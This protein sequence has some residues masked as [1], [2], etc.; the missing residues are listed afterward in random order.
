MQGLVQ[1]SGGSF[2]EPP[3]MGAP[4]QV[5]LSEAATW[6]CARNKTDGAA[7]LFLDS[8]HCLP[9]ALWSLWVGR[10][11]PTPLPLELQEPEG[12]GRVG[13]P[14][15]DMTLQLHVSVNL[16]GAASSGDSGPVGVLTGSS[17]V[18]IWPLRP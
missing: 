9:G 2:P 13:G 8:E 15:S 6:V 7:W 12:P 4:G 1:G 11:P 17:L 3:R 14:L 5:I 16:A 10:F 18:F